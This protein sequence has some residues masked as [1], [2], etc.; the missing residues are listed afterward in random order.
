MNLTKQQ[1]ISIIS[2]YFNVDINEDFE[3]DKLLFFS[4]LSGKCYYFNLNKL[5]DMFIKQGDMNEYREKSRI[6]P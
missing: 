6:N 2:R 3:L 1:I 4:A 5:V